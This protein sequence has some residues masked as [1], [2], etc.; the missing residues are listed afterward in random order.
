MFAQSHFNS[1]ACI[2]KFIFLSITKLL[3]SSTVS[4]LK[5]PVEGWIYEPDYERMPRDKLEKLQEE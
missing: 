2:T 3:F 5:R 1:W 4:T